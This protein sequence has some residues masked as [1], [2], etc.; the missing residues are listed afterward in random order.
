MDTQPNVLSATPGALLL[1]TRGDGVEEAG[2]IAPSAHN[3]ALKTTETLAPDESISF[4]DQVLVERRAVLGAS[5]SAVAFR[6]LWE[7]AKSIYNT[8]DEARDSAPIQ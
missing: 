4:G 5:S 6:E 3:V 7:S 8:L 1:A 2:L